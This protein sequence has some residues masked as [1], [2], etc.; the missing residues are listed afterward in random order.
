[1]KLRIFRFLRET[2]AEGPG[3]RACIWVQGCLTKCSGCASKHSWDLNGGYEVDVDNIISKILSTKEL[4]G[5]TFLGG[6]PFL[7]S[8][9]LG[10]IAKKVKEFGLSVVTFTGYHYEDLISK[11]DK[12]IN[13]LLKYTDLL[14][15]GPYKKELHD[16]NR[17]WVGSLNQRY[18]FLSD[19]YKH[20]ENN[21]EQYKNRIEIKI[22][23]DGQIIV[24]GM[25]NFEDLIDVINNI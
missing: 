16:I 2:Y 21:L 19:K 20:L 22:K 25:A 3:K 17:P 15:D 5:V 18:I 6:E 9:E 24:N 12:D 1:M 13:T 23:P 10:Y 7:Q 11:N 8:K 14:I 4:E